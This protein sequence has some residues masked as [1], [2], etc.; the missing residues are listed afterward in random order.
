VQT[1]SQSKNR[2]HKLLEDTN[3]KL[4]SVVSELFGVTGRHVLAALVAG[5]RDPQ[6]FK[7]R[8][9]LRYTRVPFSRPYRSVK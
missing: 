5:E 7:P 4:G 6:V 8:H 3:L 1:R 9:D 2:M